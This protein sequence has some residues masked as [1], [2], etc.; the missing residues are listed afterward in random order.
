MVGLAL[1]RRLGVKSPLA[2]GTAV[3]VANLAD[4]DILLGMLLYRD[5]WKLHRHRTHSL[6]FA[7][8]AGALLGTAGFSSVDGGVAK[9][10]LLA[11]ALTGAMIA[12]SHLVLDGVSRPQ[13]G[14]RPSTPRPLRKQVIGMSVA[15]WL[16]DVVGCGTILWA[17][18]PRV[19]RSGRQ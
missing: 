10:N 3:V 14:A 6:A 15:S 13:L 8:G 7:L 5:P 2:L 19:R 4:V 9:R 12:G 17:I 1:A 11:N 16:V 18:W